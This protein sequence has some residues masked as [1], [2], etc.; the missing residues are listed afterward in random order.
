MHTRPLNSALVPLAMLF[1]LTAALS[2]L[3]ESIGPGTYKGYYV[4][5]RWGEKMLVNGT[6]AL[7]LS[8]DVAKKLE[9]LADRPLSVEATRM[10]QPMNPGAAMITAVG[11]AEP[12]NAFPLVQIIR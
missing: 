5:S 11:K 12:T 9:P 4:V 3:A 2:A 8:D 6:S 10:D 1:L 7:F